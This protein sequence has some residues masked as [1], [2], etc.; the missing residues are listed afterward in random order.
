MLFSG[1]VTSLERVEK[2]EMALAFH[3]HGYGGC[4]ATAS[5]VELVEVVI[6]NNGPF[7]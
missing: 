7:G 1:E 6:V 3:S 2:I 4:E 5:V